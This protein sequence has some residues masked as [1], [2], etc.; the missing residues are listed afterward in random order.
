[1]ELEKGLTAVSLFAGAGGLCLGFRNAGVRILYANDFNKDACATYRLHS[2]EVTVV[3]G[4]ISKIAAEDIPDA[5]L[6]IGGPPC[7][8]FS[9]GGSRN[10][11]DPRNQLY[12]EYLRVLT[13]KQPK[14]CVFENV[15]GLL[16]MSGGEVF[17]QILS[18]L[19]T[20]GYTVF[21]QVLNAKDYGVPQ[22]RERLIV[23]GFRKDLGVT[24]FVIPKYTGPSMT[25]GD[26][27]K[28]LPEPAPE[29][30][31]TAPYSPQYLMRNRRRDWHEVAFT[32][33]A[34]AKQIAIHPSSPPMIRIHKDLSEFGKGGVTRRLS[35]RECALLQT[36]PADMEF[37]GSL[38]SKYKQVGN[39]VPPKLAE[40]VAEA[41][42]AKL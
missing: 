40:W 18:D 27:L 17:K 19:D 21:Y 41:V 24:D 10:E 8:G 29:D 7:Q 6:L 3:Q 22:S 1:M 39:A 31:C 16:S 25:I 20:A 14:A 2:P 11:A 15:K 42:K 35:Y 30:V 28:G 37:V 34:M 33:V 13:A 12:K 23:V 4:D 36:F 32:V 5:D 26:V 9:I 38:T